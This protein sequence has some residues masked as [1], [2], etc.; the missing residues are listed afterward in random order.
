MRPLA[1]FDIGDTLLTY[2]GV[3]LSWADNYVSAINAALSEVEATCDTDLLDLSVSILEFYNT[4][5]RPRKFEVA[6]GEVLSKVAKL[7]GANEIEFENAFFAYFQRKAK[8]TNYA[9]EMLGALKDAG[10]YTAALTDVPYGMPKRL[11]L[12]DIRSMTALLDRVVTSCEVCLRKP[13][14]NG[15]RRLISDFGV[16]PHDAYYIG[17]ERKDIVCAKNAEISSVLYTRSSDLDYGQDHTLC[18]LKELGAILL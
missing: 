16:E 2:E 15:L 18:N 4:R 17:N 8:P 9:L 10:V 1:I 11:V 14:P 5:T 7:Y 3:S 13:H 6:E 12:E